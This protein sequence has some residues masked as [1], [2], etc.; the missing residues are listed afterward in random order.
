[1]N[2]AL[3]TAG[4]VGNRMGQDVPKQ[5]MTIDN[6][7][8]IIYTMLA[9]QN[10]AEIDHIAVVCLNGWETMLQAYAKQY[11]ITKLTWIFPSGDSNQAS[12][13]NG[14]RGLREAGCGDDSLV[15]IHDGVR[16]LVSTGI[17]SRNISTALRYGAAVTG[18]K[19]KEVIMELENDVVK[20]IG[21][22]RER[23][24][25]TQTPHTYHLGVIYSSLLEAEQ[26]GLEMAAACN[27]VAFLGEHPQ[28]FVEG[29]ERNG[30]KLTNPEDID[31][32][33]ALLHTEKELWIK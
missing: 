20:Y 24:V 22:P 21:T 23:L 25:R 4:G 17:I 19:C 8:V 30:L 27:L 33:Q 16:P 15:L 12:I 14:I 32:F 2:I 29:S 3:I 13:F 26:K 6:C 18:L 9:F 28:C 31:L 11:R 7:P 10:C 5:F 1:M